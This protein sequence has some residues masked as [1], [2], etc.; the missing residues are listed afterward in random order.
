[1]RFKLDEPVKP[2]VI[3]II[4][5]LFWLVRILAL[6]TICMAC[7]LLVIF[8][9]DLV[10]TETVYDYIRA[11]FKGEE[12]ISPLWLGLPLF[13]VFSWCFQKYL[14]PWVKRVDSYELCDLFQKAKDYPVI[15]TYLSS[16]SSDG[17]MISKK[18][19]N[20]LVK[21]VQKDVKAKYWNLGDK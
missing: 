12:T 13:W 15:E 5:T 10:R 17:R 8:V 18:E 19:Y 16:V 3:N 2:L 9:I 11:I 4:L 6:V 14:L 20:C 1:M 7:F 21:M